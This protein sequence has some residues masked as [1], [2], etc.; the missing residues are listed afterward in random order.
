MSARLPA[1]DAPRGAVRGRSASAKG[2]VVLMV[3]GA[4]YNVLKFY[5][6]TTYVREWYIGSDEK[7]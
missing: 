2:F 5:M 4:K 6:Y 1:R 7:F 3:R